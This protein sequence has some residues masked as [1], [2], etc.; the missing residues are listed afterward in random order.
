MGKCTR[1]WCELDDSADPEGGLCILHSPAPQK[2]ENAFQAALQNHRERR[3]DDF[4]WIVFPSFRFDHDFAGDVS[5]KKA[6]FLSDAG[7]SGIEFGGNAAFVEA[8]FNGPVHFGH[9]TFNGLVNFQRARF[10]HMA[11]FYFCKFQKE[12]VFEGTEFSDVSFCYAEFTGEVAFFS[13]SLSEGDF[14]FSKAGANFSLAK[15][16]RGPFD[17]VGCKLFG[18]T[19]FAANAKSPSWFGL[20]T[21]T[22]HMAEASPS[23]IFSGAEVNFRQLWADGMRSTMKLNQRQRRGHARSFDSLTFRIPIEAFLRFKRKRM[24]SKS[25]KLNCFHF[26]RSSS[27]LV[28]SRPLGDDSNFAGSR[29]RPVGA[30]GLK[31]RFGLGKCF[32]GSS[33]HP[34]VPAFPPQDAVSHPGMHWPPSRSWRS[35]CR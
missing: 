18:M 1:S 26:W 31:D 12:V 34:N 16:E 29:W 17:F 15:F 24:I 27:N 3:G 32:Q 28:I 30:H 10:L 5:F 25:M 11:S 4:N 7:F 14:S 6:I 8:T 21:S 2:D 33:G 35:N 23:P 22:W 20:S 13:A 19:Y 9:S